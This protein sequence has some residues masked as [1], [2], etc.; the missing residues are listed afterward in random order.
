MSGRGVA[1][2][3]LACVALAGCGEKPE[4]DLSKLAV[5]GTVDISPAPSAGVAATTRNALFRFVGRVKPPAAN[6]TLTPPAGRAASV[7]RKANGRF[8]AKVRKLR[9]GANH[10]ALRGTTPGLR[11]WTLAVTVTRR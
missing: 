5:T 3:L 7:R 1:A 6:V 2:L 10:F 11:P 4:P 9:R 8:S